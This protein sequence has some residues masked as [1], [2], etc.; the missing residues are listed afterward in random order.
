MSSESYTL[1]K[2]KFSSASNEEKSSTREAA[3]ATS[4]THLQSLLLPYVA[5]APCEIV[6]VASV[7]YAV[8]THSSWSQSAPYLVG[9]AH[10][11][12]GATR[13]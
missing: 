13:E 3:S 7:T 10:G 11:A 9:S 12:V 5:A 1:R 6:P 4:T 2:S 8:P